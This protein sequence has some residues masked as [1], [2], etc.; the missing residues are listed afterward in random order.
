MEKIGRLKYTSVTADKLKTPHLPTFSRFAV[1]TN[2][3]INRTSASKYGVALR[4]ELLMKSHLNHSKTK[5]H[6]LGAIAFSVV[7]A[8]G[9]GGFSVGGISLSESVVS[10]DAWR[11]LPTAPATIR[12]LSKTVEVSAEVR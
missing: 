11:N 9:I 12:Q 5:R 2:V 6:N 8:L 10:A 4:D 3:T 7:C 1:P